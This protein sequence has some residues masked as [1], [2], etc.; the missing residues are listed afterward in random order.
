MKNLL[1]LLCLVL[2]ISVEGQSYRPFPTGDAY[3]TTER[4]DDFW[5]PTGEYTIYKQQGDTIIDTVS[6]NKLYVRYHLTTQFVYKGGLREENQKIYYFPKD[7]AQEYLLYN[8]DVQVGDT[9][10]NLFSEWNGPY[11]YDTL[12]V[13]AINGSEY[14]LWWPGFQTLIYEGVGESRGPIPKYYEGSVSGGDILRCFSDSTGMVYNNN[15]PCLTTISETDDNSIIYIYPTPANDMVYFKGYQNFQLI[16]IINISGNTVLAQAI[17][18]NTGEVTISGLPDGLYLV[19]L[20][21]N[22]KI[23]RKKLVKI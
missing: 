3:W 16:K 1:I 14:N 21:G 12:V 18:S 2:S 15:G 4:L 8:F 10:T 7:S 17:N 20:I 23:Y 13:S 9:V 19:E 6:Y 5:Q 11:E 22:G